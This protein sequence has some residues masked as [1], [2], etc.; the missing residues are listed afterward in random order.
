[1][2][3]TFHIGGASGFGAAIVRRFAQ[4]GAKVCIADLNESGGHDLVASLSSASVSMHRLNVTH[5]QDWES[6]TEKVYA[7]H[8][9]IDILINNAGTTYSNKARSCPVLD[10]RIKRY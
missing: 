3:L 10:T 5:R 1:M 7:A 6:V 8:G 2:K 9:R 4:E